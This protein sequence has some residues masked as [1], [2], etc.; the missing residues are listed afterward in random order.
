M[1]P[2]VSFRHAL[3]INMYNR[4]SITERTL[5]HV[6]VKALIFALMFI[7]LN[8]WI[9]SSFLHCEEEG[10][11]A[12]TVLEEVM[13]GDALCGQKRLW[14]SLTHYKKALAIKPSAELYLKIGMVYTNSSYPSREMA[15]EF[16]IQAITSNKE[17]APAYKA[18][19]EIYVEKR[20]SELAKDAFGKAEALFL[21]NENKPEAVLCK[22]C[23][24]MADY[25]V[26]ADN[27]LYKDASNIIPSPWENLYRYEFTDKNFLRLYP[28]YKAQCLSYY[29]SAAE[30]TFFK[31]PQALYKLGVVLVTCN[32][33][34]DAVKEYKAALSL[35]PAY[36]DAL[37]ALATTPYKAYKQHVNAEAL[38][39]EVILIDPEWYIAH[40]QL[41]TELKNKNPS[42]AAEEFY[43]AGTLYLKKS[44][45]GGKLEMAKKCL[46][47]IKHLC[48]ESSPAYKKLKHEIHERNLYS[49]G[50]LSKITIEEDIELP[51]EM[52]KI[53][54]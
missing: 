27:L 41:A 54:E 21:K 24:R 1:E 19:G 6:L 38:L 52:I 16:V 7:V 3:N 30:H 15:E 8:I 13:K 44:K 33:Y 48:G 22:R 35:R 50:Q 12:R 14:E 17:Y 40:F 53:T 5:A 49:I 42:Q 46:Y 31:F 23:K 32:R 25:I 45:A 37:Y 18:L 26:A 29:T 39:K 34:S 2:D 36:K 4:L 43:K 20:Q 10:N 11:D 51:P 47:E 28:L 9:S